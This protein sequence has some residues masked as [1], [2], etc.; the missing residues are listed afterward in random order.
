MTFEQITVFASL[1]KHGSVTRAARELH[2][3]Q[4]NLSKHLK[5]LEDAVHL[6]LFTRSAK[7]L[8]LTPHGE[9]FLREVE[10][11]VTQWQRVSG[12]YYRN[13]TPKAVDTALR[14][15]GTYGAAATL[16]AAPLAAFRNVHPEVEVT[17]CSNST[18]H[19]EEMVLTGQVELA[20]CPKPPVS[21]LLASE[22]YL[23]SKL[24]LFVAGDDAL[25]KQKNWTL[26]DMVK[27][28]LFIRGETG[29][30]GGTAALL[31]KIHELG[32]EPKIALRCEQPEAIKEAVRRHSGIGVL[33][34]ETIERELQ[35]G[36]F[37]ALKIRDLDIEGQLYIL[38][39][40]V[41]PLS[42]SAAAFLQVLRQERENRKKLGNRQQA[43]G[44]R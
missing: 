39:H 11:L 29:A 9:V 38:S 20:L 2:T 13:G 25:A 14:V 37:K 18:A 19:L 16:L 42:P 40:K 34:Q 17:V 8:A 7:G 44:N 30:N 35:N 3:T 32:I 12:K 36:E 23:T 10:P 28:P 1:A 15:A 4:P 26:A 43:R 21:P 31:E 33:Y 41:R 5:S 24:V 22:H 6:R 27:Q